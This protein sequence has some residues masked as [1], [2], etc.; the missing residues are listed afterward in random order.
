MPK[1]FDFSSPPF[2]RLR[3]MEV[4]RVNHVVDVVFFRTGETILKADQLPDHF[5]IVIKGVIEERADGEVVAVHERGDGFDS[6]ILVHQAIRH[7]FVVREEAICYAIPIEDFI[8]LT[9]NNPAFATFFYKDITHKLEA[10]GQRT[11]GPQPLGAMT[12][13]VSQALVHKPVFVDAGT[14][15]HEAAVHMDREAQRALLVHDGDRI[16]IFTEVDL[17]RSAVAQRRPLDTPVR[18]LVHHG[19]VCIDEDGFLFEAALLMAR[20]RV[21]HL[22]VRREDE[23]VGV[24]D[25]ANVLSSLANQADP[26]GA[27]IDH[28]QTPAELNEASE[29]ITFLIRQ[30]H[31]SGTKIGFITE[32]STDLHRRMT[33]KLFHQLAPEGLAEHGCLVVMGSEGRGEYLMKTDQDNGMILADGYVPPDWDAFRHRFTD[34]LIEAGFPPCPGEIMVRNPAWSKPLDKWCTDVRAWVLTPDEQAL[35]NVAI[36]YDADVV[37]GDA[38]LLDQAKQYLFDLLADYSSFHARFARAID[39]FDTPLGLFTTFVTGK[40]AHKHELDLKKGGIFPLMHGVRAL[41]LEKRLPETNTVQRIRRLQA[42]GL[43]DKARGQELTEAF[44]F[45]LGLR[46]SARLE[47]MRLHQPLDNFIRPDKISKLERDLLKDSL[48]IVKSFKEM[49]RHHFHLNRF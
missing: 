36:F 23:I 25:A 8:E 12:M 17:T 9:A 45:L 22:V 29:R 41:A 28:A 44:N 13:R 18:D 11:T 4:D 21:R 34:A 14:T 31:E 1:A 20:R 7:D 30:L 39:M 32:L 37:T 3:P 24:L 5:Y 40:G 48:Q 47:K 19:L 35:M 33:A 42:T 6:E 43:F 26:I 38:R 16:G 27:L 10:L 46:L 49:I 2:D 15:L